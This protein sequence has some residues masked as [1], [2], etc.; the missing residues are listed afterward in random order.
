MISRLELAGMKGCADGVLGV[1]DGGVEAF[2]V[3]ERLCQMLWDGRA[4]V[5][6][7]KVRMYLVTVARIKQYL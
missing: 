5:V 4:E 2:S 6:G 7:E 1:R 3:S